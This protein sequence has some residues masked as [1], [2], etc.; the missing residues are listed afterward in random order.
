MIAITIT[1][2]ARVTSDG[3]QWILWV[4]RGRERK[5][6]TGWRA[7][8]YCFTRT[9]LRGAVARLSPDGDLSLLDQLPEFHPVPG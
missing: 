3:R 9:G 4:R 5:K 2:R 8:A 7:A 6:A 1:D